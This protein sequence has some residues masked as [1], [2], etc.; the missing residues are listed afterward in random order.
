MR[1]ELTWFKDGS[2][3]AEYK[4][5]LSKVRRPGPYSR[6]FL[7]VLTATEYSKAAEPCIDFQQETVD[8]GLLG[9]L[10]GA[11][12]GGEERMIRT[13]L[14]LWNT[15]NPRDEPWTIMDLRGLDPDNL[16]VCL[17]AIE[18]LVSNIG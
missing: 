17:L 10:G 9:R 11:P 12:S 7:Y 4:R 2:H 5:L 6:S 14:H 8:P 3:R 13:A 15:T 18:H 16:R 1:H